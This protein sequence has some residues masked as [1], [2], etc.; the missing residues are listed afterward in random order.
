ME[1]G[2]ARVNTPSGVH[3]RSSP[4]NGDNVILSLPN[5]TELEIIRRQGNWTRVKAEDDRR[6]WVWSDFLKPADAPELPHL[7]EIPVSYE[8]PLWPVLVSVGLLFVAVLAYVLR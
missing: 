2:K 7:P 4:E 3:L 6:G 8:W 1:Y 5:G